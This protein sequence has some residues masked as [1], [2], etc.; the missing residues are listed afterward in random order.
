MEVVHQKALRREGATGGVIVRRALY[1]V[2]RLREDRLREG[3]SGSRTIKP[4]DLTGPFCDVVVPLQCLVERHTIVIP[5]GVSSSK[6]D[7][8]GFY[9]PLPLNEETELELYVLYE[10]RGSLHEVIVGDRETLSLPY[11]KH[12]VPM[13]QGP[14]GPFSATNA[15]LLRA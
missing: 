10:F 9:N 8:P 15:A 3:L 12:A 13:D 5:G 2:L 14:R 4:E 6:S 11:R 1:G 7:L